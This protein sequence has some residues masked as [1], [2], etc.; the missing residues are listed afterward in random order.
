MCVCG[1]VCGGGGG[2]VDA[3]ERSN[4]CSV[5]GEMETDGLVAVHP[6]GIAAMAVHSYGIAAVACTSIFGYYTTALM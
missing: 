1:C 3:C 4:G 2:G 6:Y 5:H